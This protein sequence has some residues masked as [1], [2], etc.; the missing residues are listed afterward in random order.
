MKTI[1]MRNGEV[2]RVPETMAKILVEGHLAV[3]VPKSEW[4]KV[5]EAK[6]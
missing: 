1:K 4:K 2:R 3:Y 5:R 6:K